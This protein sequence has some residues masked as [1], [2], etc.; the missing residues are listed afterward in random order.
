MVFIT[1]CCGKRAVNRENERKPECI[2]IFVLQRDGGRE[3][4]AEAEAE[5]AAKAEELEAA[6]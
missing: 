3:Q 4:L 5:L 6:Q 2:P 1:Q